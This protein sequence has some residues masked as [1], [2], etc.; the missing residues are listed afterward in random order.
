[1]IETKEN[2]FLF[3]EIISIKSVGKKQTYDFTVPVTNCFFANEVL[4]HNSGG[5]GEAPDTILLFDN[6]Y[7]RTKEETEK[8]KINI[9]IEQRHGDSGMCSIVADLGACKF[10]NAAKENKYEDT[11]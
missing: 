10:N 11:I 4:C 7:R 3:D 2:S 8:G 5:V 1:M 6:L 9:I